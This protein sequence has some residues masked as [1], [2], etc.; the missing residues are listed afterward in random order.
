[1]KLPATL[2]LVAATALAP[3]MAHAQYRGNVDTYGPDCSYRARILPHDKYNSSGMDLRRL[4]GNAAV[5]AILRQ[6]R[7]N[8]VKAMGRDAGSC[9]SSYEERA[10]FER[11]IKA[12]RISSSARNAIING[13][14][15]IRVDVY[16]GPRGNDY[17]EVSI[18]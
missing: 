10:N 15:A 12:S 2:A 11:L 13:T 17:I 4:R 14:P 5:A 9:L 7:A 16:Y 3:L 1:M 8:E 18:R 6:N